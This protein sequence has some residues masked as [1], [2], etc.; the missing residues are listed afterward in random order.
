[1]NAGAD[2]RWMFGRTIGLGALVRFARG[3]VDLKSM[4]DRD[5]SV[6]AAGIHAGA[7]LRVAF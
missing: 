7:G 3:S 6:R 4:D 2:L 1:M 5:T